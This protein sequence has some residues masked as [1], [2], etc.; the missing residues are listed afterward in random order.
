MCRHTIVLDHDKETPSIASTSHFPRRK[1]VF[2]AVYLQVSIFFTYWWLHYNNW[3]RQLAQPI[4]PTRHAY[5]RPTRVANIKPAALPQSNIFVGISHSDK[6]VGDAA[7][8]FLLEAACVYNMESY[9]LLGRRDSHS[10]LSR[11]IALF[12]QHKYT[13]VAAG[14]TNSLKCTKLIHI[15]VAPNEANLIRRTSSRLMH[16]DVNIS[17]LRSN[18]H[19]PNNPLDREN[20]IAN[21]KRAREYQRQML[22]TVFNDREYD[23]KHS[24]IAVL[25][26]DMFAYPP[27]VNV[28]ETSNQYMRPMN[29]KERDMP[30]FHAICANGLQGA[31]QQLSK[32]HSEYYDTFATILLPDL[33]LHSKR[34]NMP[35]SEI[36]NW[37]LEEGKKESDYA[38]SETSYHPV[39][40]QSCFGGFTLYR[41]D[42]W[43]SSG[44]RYDLYNKRDIKFIGQKEHHACEHVVFHQ[45]LREQYA[46]TSGGFSIAVQPDLL[47]LWHLV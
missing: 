27:L 25:D 13:T 28:L 19:V 37:F 36:L 22:R 4:S 17:M 9:I 32:H 8:H 45:C 29:D 35:Q 16:D 10:S 40:V 42:K 39:P 24:V 23:L 41:A 7:I 15:T 43:L 30:K 5:Q 33:W 2:V 3:Y 44:C 21:I 26:L 20:R 34:A 31:G 46:E 14:G 12:A 18:R 1:V 38:E 47:T 11:K 6:A